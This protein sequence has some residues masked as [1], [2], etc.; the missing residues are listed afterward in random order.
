MIILCVMVL[1]VLLVLIC[2]SRFGLRV[3]VGFRMVVLWL[4]LVLML[5][6]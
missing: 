6:L 1:L 3:S 2:V 5:M 4:D